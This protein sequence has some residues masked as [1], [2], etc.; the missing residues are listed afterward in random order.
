MPILLTSVLFS[1]WRNLTD[2]PAA[3]PIA[4]ALAANQI[5]NPKAE[6]P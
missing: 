6:N 4:T 5:L 3:N 2:K 1:G